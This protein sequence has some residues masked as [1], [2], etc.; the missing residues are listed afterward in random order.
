MGTPIGLAYWTAYT[1]LG[2]YAK[3][4]TLAIP[5]RMIPLS[6]PFQF[7][8]FLSKPISGSVK[9]PFAAVDKYRH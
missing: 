7:P 6:S 1:A 5:P 8:P 4:G 3:Y 9:K 2:D